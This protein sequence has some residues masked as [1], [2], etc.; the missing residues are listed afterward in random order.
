MNEKK[1]QKT[2]AQDS[3]R[4]TTKMFKVFIDFSLPPSQMSVGFATVKLDYIRII[5]M[6][7]PAT[8]HSRPLCV[9]QA[10][11]ILFESVSL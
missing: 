5:Y 8:T 9:V 11:G 3:M 1:E 2:H 6:H 10:I 4:K 7:M